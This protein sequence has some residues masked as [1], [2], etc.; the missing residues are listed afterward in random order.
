M[1]TTDEI[2]KWN[3]PWIRVDDDKG[4][5][6]EEFIMNLNMT[7]IKK[8][9]NTVANDIDFDDEKDKE[10]YNEESDDDDGDILLRD[11]YDC[12]SYEITTY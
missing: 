1:V 6:H 10:R 12:L 7:K 11:L 8:K 4:G 2:S 5:E 9:D 3:G